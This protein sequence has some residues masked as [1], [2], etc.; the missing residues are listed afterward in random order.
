VK[1]LK[2]VGML[3][4]IG[5]GGVGSWLAP[6]LAKLSNHRGIVL[7]D[8]DRLE[9]KNLDRQLF[10][11]DDIGKYKT[12]ALFLRYPE[13]GRGSGGIRNSYFAAGLAETIGLNSSDILF[14]C[15]D[16]HACRR[17]VLAAC[18][19]FH[20]CAVIG[21]NEYEEAEA[22]WYESTFQG[23]PNDPGCFYPEILTDRSGDP[24]A[25]E[26]CTGDAQVR[27]PQLVL[28]NDWASSLMTQLYWFHTQVRPDLDKEETQE[29]WPIHHKLNAFKLQTIR[30]GD[31]LQAQAA[32]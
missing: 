5:C 24:L 9:A 21:A 22:Y 16:N 32:A 12:D 26:G 15:A 30:K 20:C 1:R 25:P 7:I 27:T 4:L 29:F 17:A 18:N 6:K 3:Y 19:R 28:A 11:Q 2:N 31:R 10:S 23:T 8:G 13:L 14:C